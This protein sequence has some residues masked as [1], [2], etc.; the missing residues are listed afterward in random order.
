MADQDPLLDTIAAA[1]RLGVTSSLI[2]KLRLGED[3]PPFLKIGALV[4]YRPADLDAWLESRRRISTSRTE[5][6]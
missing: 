3:G 2:R 1:R 5:E 4:R 6:P